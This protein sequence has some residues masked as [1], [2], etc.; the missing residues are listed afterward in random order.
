LYRRRVALRR[1]RSAWDAIGLCLADP[2]RQFT[3]RVELVELIQNLGVLGLLTTVEAAPLSTDSGKP[4]SLV[5]G[6]TRQPILATRLHDLSPSYRRA[7]AGDWA[8]GNTKLRTAEHELRRELGQRPVRRLR[9]QLRRLGRW[10]FVEHLDLMLVLT[11]LAALGVA[12]LR[13]R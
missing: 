7:L 4:G 12:L 6:L 2:D 11:G 10:V 3:S 5:L 9:R 8:A 13:A 1:L